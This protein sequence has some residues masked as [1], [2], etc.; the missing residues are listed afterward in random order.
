MD[1][2]TRGMRCL[3]EK[4]V[5]GGPEFS[6]SHACQHWELKNRPGRDGF[7]GC[8]LMMSLIVFFIV[9]GSNCLAKEADVRRGHRIYGQYCTPCHGQQGNGRGP[10]AKN[11][12]LQPPPRDHTNGFYMN[13]QPDLRLFKVIKFGGKANNLSHIMPQWKH[14]LSDHQIFDIIA[15]L[16]TIAKNPPYKKPT[17]SNWG[18]NPYSADERQPLRQP[19]GEK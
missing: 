10:R 16:R 17:T 1:N 15:Y 11:E 19:A 13:M 8:Y 4:R 5:D 3:P 18:Y 6:V 9:C 7:A 12:R 2:R 14:V